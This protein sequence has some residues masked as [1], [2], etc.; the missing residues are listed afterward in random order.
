[1]I[2]GYMGASLGYNEVH[3]NGGFG[4]MVSMNKRKR[5]VVFTFAFEE[6][7]GIYVCIFG[8]EKRGVES[9]I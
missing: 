9:L 1:V 6:K 8:R 2:V 3:M 7:D 4:M 5:K